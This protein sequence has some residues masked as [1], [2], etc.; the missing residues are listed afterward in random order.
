MSDQFLEQRV[1][2]YSCPSSQLT[3]FCR[4][5]SVE[6]KYGAFS[7]IPK[8]NDEVFSRNSQH[9]H[10]PRKLTCQNHE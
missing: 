2:V 3:T 4:K 1:D 10:D 9:P 5:L 6:M 8:A 7:M